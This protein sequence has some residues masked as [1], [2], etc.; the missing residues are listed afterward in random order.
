[1]KSLYESLFDVD[2]NVSGV[3]DTV[4]IYD[5]AIKYIKKNK[6][7]HPNNIGSFLFDMD[8]EDD[9]T[10]IREYLE[11]L[12]YRVTDDMLAFYKFLWELM[13]ADPQWTFIKSSIMED[14]EMYDDVCKEIEPLKIYKT[15]NNKQSEYI[16]KVLG[17]I[18]DIKNGRDWQWIPDMDFDGQSWILS[19]T[20]HMSSVQ[21]RVML[22]LMKSNKKLDISI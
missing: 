14:G 9:E 11:N 3:E 8:G 21:K 18:S 19:T 15:I 10:V 2:D 5:L 20:S 22:E 7:I 6:G 12:D 13:E 1:M 16:D 4:K 17:M